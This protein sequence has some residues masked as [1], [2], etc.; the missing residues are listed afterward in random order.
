MAKLLNRKTIQYIKQGQ[1]LYGEKGLSIKQFNK[2][3]YTLLEL[4][5]SR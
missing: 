2:D 3:S 5:K 4:K 1:V